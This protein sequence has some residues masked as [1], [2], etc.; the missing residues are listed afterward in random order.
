MRKEKQSADLPIA[1]TRSFKR[2]SVKFM[3]HVLIA[4]IE[5]LYKKVMASEAINDDMPLSSVVTILGLFCLSLVIIPVTPA[6]DLLRNLLAYQ[7]GYD[8]SKM[9]AFSHFPQYDLYYLFDVSVGILHQAIG[10]Y[11]F[12]PVQLA[13]IG[14]FSFGYLWM[15]RGVNNNLRFASLIVVLQLVLPRLLLGR[16]AG[17]EA[18]LFL[19]AFAAIEDERVKW[20]VHVIIGCLMASFY[21]LFWLYLIPLAFMRRVYAIPLMAGFCGWAWYGG[22]EYFEVI[23]GLLFAKS[24]RP[25]MISEAAS[26]LTAILPNAYILLPMCFFWR[27]NIKVVL[28]A[29]WFVASNQLRYME[30]FVP[31]FVSVVRSWNYRPH[32]FVVMSLVLVLFTSRQYQN[33][34]APSTFKGQ[35]PPGSVVLDLTASTYFQILYTNPKIKVSPAF[36]ITWTDK[37]IQDA[38]AGAV[39][40]GHF[41]CSSVEK[42]GFDFIVEDNLRDIPACFQLAGVSKKYRIWKKN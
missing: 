42:Y 29:V 5:T 36:E 34:F 21:H 8:Y 28:S 1:E 37:K 12:I 32:F 9:F 17:F 23:K 26:S 33:H 25:F 35:F 7:V 24:E 15:L 40:K 18:G 3:I 38:V 10:Y 4:K 13:C 2:T 30:I 22:L 14:I 11:A 39:N 41:E 27:K 19:V 6:D 20:W 31:L 16:P